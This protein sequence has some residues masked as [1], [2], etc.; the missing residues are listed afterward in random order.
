M[1]FGE[2]KEIGEFVCVFAERREMEV[3]I[4][5]VEVEVLNAYYDES[6]ERNSVG[7]SRLS[8]TLC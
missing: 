1:E 4:L 6:D 3:D 2:F 8:N 7:G 5:R